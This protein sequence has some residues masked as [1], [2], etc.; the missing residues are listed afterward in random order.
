MQ[1]LIRRIGSI[2]S[3]QLGSMATPWNEAS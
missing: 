1:A 2:L 3:G